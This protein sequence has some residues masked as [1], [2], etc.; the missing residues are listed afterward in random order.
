MTPVLIGA[1]RCRRLGWDGMEGRGMLMPEGNLE[2]SAALV[3]AARL[4]NHGT[5][6]VR[7]DMRLK[8]VVWVGRVSSDWVLG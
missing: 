1:D 5:R 3:L 4:V 2:S 7:L 6:K 8:G